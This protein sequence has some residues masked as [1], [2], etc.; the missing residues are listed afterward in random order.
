MKNKGFT[1]IELVIVIAFIAITASI[2]LLVHNGTMPE[3]LQRG[4]TTCKGGMLFNVDSN[5]YQTQI[6]GS[7][8][9]GIACQ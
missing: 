8:G 6:I 4:G 5:G 2:F 7:N 3:T 9:Y 1:L